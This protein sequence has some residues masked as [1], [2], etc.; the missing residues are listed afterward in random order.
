MAS[1]FG[2]GHNYFY[3]SNTRFDTLI[4]FAIEVGSDLA[5]NDVERNSVARLKN[6][7]EHEFWNGIDIDLDKYFLTI[8]ERKFWAAVF[9]AIAWRVYHRQIGNQ[10]DSTWQVS[11][12]SEC[13]MISLMLTHL[14]WK[15]ERDWYPEDSLAEGAR[16][17][18]MR[19]QN[20][21]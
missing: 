8:D 13:R 12:I 2:D 10:N 7:W 4:N 21:A 1:A 3:V 11:V 6:S 20:K 19:L 9:L 14:V 18:P 5:K 15:E 17:D 16:P